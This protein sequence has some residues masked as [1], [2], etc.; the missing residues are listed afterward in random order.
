MGDRATLRARIRFLQPM[1]REIGAAPGTD[2]TGFACVPELRVGDRLYTTWHE[3]VE[4]E[5]ASLELPITEPI[6]S[7][8]LFSFPKSLTV[9]PIYDD[10]HRLFGS[11]RRRLDALSGQIEYRIEAID[12]EVC[13]FTGRIANRTPVT[14]SEM[15]DPNALLLRTFASTHAI[16]EAHGAEFLSMTDPPPRYANAAEACRNI[17]CWP[18]LV[19]DEQRGVRGTILASPII[20]S[21]YPAIAPESAGDL[22]DS[23][24]IDE[25][26]TLRVMTMTD[27]EKREMRGVDEFARRILERTEGLQSSQLLKMHGTMRDVQFPGPDFFDAHT[28][29]EHAEV[30]GVRLEPGNRVRIQPKNRADAIDLVLAGKIGV[31]EAIEQDAEG[32]LHFALVL[33]DDPGR[34]LG[35][36]RQPGHRFFYAAEEV[37]PLLENA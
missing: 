34:D 27:A 22:C 3:A 14:L 11:I 28:R 29:L 26:L 16:L 7:A 8:S 20:L 30:R 5:I 31:I 24:E 4:R 6:R 37:E 35:M 25:I 13:K 32:R 2:E 23:A 36:L 19:G 15:R 21:D 9:E 1:A 33:E 17:G 10:E 18:V 12:V